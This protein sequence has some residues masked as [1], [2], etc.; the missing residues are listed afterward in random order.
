VDR[1]GASLYGDPCR[2]CDYR[3]S[4]H[5]EDALLLISEL[6]GAFWELL[7]E[8]TGSERHPDLTWSVG[9]YVCHVADNLRIW[10][11]R[12]AGAREGAGPAIGPYDESLLGVARN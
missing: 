5:E 6:P 1:W 4:I 8:A 12:V 10:S 9:A 2:E 11:E 7:S 3:W